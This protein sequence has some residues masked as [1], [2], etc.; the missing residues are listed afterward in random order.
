VETTRLLTG[1][2]V[3]KLKKAIREAE[4][5]TSGELRVFLEDHSEDGPLDRASFLF[6]Q[7]GM[8][9]T[10]LRN[11]VLIYLAFKDRKFSIIGDYGIHEK[12]GY[13]FWGSIKNKMQNHFRNGNFFEGIH[14]AIQECGHSLSEHF[15]RSGD[16][17]N[18]LSDD[19][20]FGNELKP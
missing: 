11:G 15:P 8:H 16:D 18:E 14:E 1:D 6:Q 20:M 2:Q 19:I 10:E 17:R 5:K 3:G 4:A 9:K 7:L 13:D 12:V